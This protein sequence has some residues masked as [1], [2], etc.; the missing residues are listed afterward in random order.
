MAEGKKD[1]GVGDPI[2]NLARGCPRETEERDDGQFFFRFFNGCPPVAHLNPT[3]S[4][5]KFAPPMEE[6]NAMETIAS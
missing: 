6:L 3:P 2:K 5:A 4:S 1:E